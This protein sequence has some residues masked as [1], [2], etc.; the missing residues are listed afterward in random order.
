LEQKKR[1]LEQI[2]AKTMK[3]CAKISSMATSDSGVAMPSKF[4][5]K[6]PSQ[7][8]GTARATI[9]TAVRAAHSPFCCVCFFDK[10]PI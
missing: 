1:D 10:L 2:R 4:E 6:W 8:V 9:G 3:I 7:R 5:D